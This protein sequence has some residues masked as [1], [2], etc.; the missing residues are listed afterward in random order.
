MVTTGDVMAPVVIAAEGRDKAGV[1]ASSRRPFLFR[2]RDRRAQGPGCAGSVARRCGAGKGGTG[3]LRVASP[4]SSQGRP[5]GGAI[6][7]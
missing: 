2:S 7:L 1:E 6:G 3:L 5:L 4:C